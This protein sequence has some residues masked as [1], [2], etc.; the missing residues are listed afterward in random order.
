M[1]FI[2]DFPDGVIVLWYGRASQAP[3]KVAVCVPIFGRLES[4]G[5]R[6]GPGRRHDYNYD[7]DY[8]SY[9]SHKTAYPGVE[10]TRKPPT[11]NIVP[12]YIHIYC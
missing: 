5:V 10:S 2:S 6:Q 3:V 1:I 8:A 9:T 11:H 4:N 7:Y 12:T